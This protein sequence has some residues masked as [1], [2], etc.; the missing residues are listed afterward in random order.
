LRA[1][2]LTPWPPSRDGKGERQGAAVRQKDRYRVQRSPIVPPSS[3]EGGQG[4]RF[5]LPITQYVAALAME[6]SYLGRGFGALALTPFGAVVH[7]AGFALTLALAALALRGRRRVRS[8]PFLDTRK[9]DA[10]IRPAA[11][12]LPFEGEGVG[13]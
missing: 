5:V 3:R 13:G 8:R 1:A 9:G 11:P 2:D 12:P 7:G 6:P 10:T 4:V